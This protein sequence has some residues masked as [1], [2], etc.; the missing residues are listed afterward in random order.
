MEHPSGQMR[1]GEYILSGLES[2]SCSSFAAIARGPVPHAGSQGC[3]CTRLKRPRKDW[4]FWLPHG[5]FAKATAVGLPEH[6]LAGLA[7]TPDQKISVR[8]QPGVQCRPVRIPI[9]TLVQ[10]RGRNWQGSTWFRCGCNQAT[11]CKALDS[12]LDDFVKLGILV[13][14]KPCSSFGRKFE[15]TAKKAGGNAARGLSPGERGRS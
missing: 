15:F 2:I 14:A 7:D 13:P 12:G 1:P 6:D 10:T 5:L 3:G 11:P 8:R 9:R 4:N